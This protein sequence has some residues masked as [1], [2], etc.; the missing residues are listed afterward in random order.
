MTTT[1]FQLH[2]RRTQTEPNPNPTFT[3]LYQNRTEPIIKEPSW[4]EHEPKILLF[5]PISMRNVS[6]VHWWQVSSWPYW[7][8]LHWALS[9]ASSCCWWST[10]SDTGQSRFSAHRHHCSRL[11]SLPAL[12]LFI[13]SMCA[14]VSEI[15]RLFFS[16]PLF[17]TF[18]HFM[19]S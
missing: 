16:S 14:S 8:A 12:W 18:C 15:C 2:R 4:T 11:Y 13:G 9:S 1:C 17:L 10:D 6:G 5:L 19:K 7:L 3:E